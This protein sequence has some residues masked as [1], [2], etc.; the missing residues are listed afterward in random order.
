MAKK[1]NDRDIRGCA[2]E[3]DMLPSSPF[4]L[5][6]FTPPLPRDEFVVS[7]DRDIS[8]PVDPSLNFDV[9]ELD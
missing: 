9:R 1:K 6:L 8:S 7:R 5:P 3:R 2:G 4:F